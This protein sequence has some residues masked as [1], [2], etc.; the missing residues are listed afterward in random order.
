[1]AIGTVSM[2]GPGTLTIGPAGAGQLIAQA[3]VRAARVIPTEN[4]TRTDEKPV[5]SGE[6]LAASESATYS[7]TLQV[8][9]IQDASLNG[10]IDYSYDNAGTT[11][12]FV[13]KP[14]NAAAAQ[15]AGSLR[16]VPIEFG[17]DVNDPSPESQ[18]TFAIIGTPAFTPN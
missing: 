7:Y 3:Q 10:I 12:V 16:V 15:V 5:L 11:K 13:F 18:V 1:M 14:A 9:F 17:G 8:T 6:K 4:V 2:L